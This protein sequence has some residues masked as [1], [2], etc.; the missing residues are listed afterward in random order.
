M[1]GRSGVV[2]LVGVTLVLVAFA[3][4]VVLPTSFDDYRVVAVRAA[5]DALGQVRT[6]GLVVE[7]DL[8]GRVLAPY[9]T[10]VLWQ[11]R[12]TVGTAQSDLAGEEVPDERAGA[13]Q[14]QIVPLLAE[15]VRR[16]NE[17]GLAVDRD[18]R[19]MRGA[20][21]ALRDLGERL[22]AFVDGHR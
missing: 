6:V 2:W 4:P 11:A 21:R 17:A 13:L 5:Q 7:A 19:A 18:E 12:D 14:R 9:V 16:V 8:E 1:I 15:S 22:R 10:Q 3:V 20:V